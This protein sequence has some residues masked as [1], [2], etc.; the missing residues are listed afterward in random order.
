MDIGN[1]TTVHSQYVSRSS[2]VSTC[3][4]AD[5]NTF[6][7]VIPNACRTFDFTLLFEQSFLSLAPSLLLVLFSCFRLRT[8]LGRDNK[9]LPSKLHSSKLVS[10]L[11]TRSL[12]DVT[13][14]RSSRLFATHAHS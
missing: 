12:C 4:F 13:D 5:D 6:G 2:S 10:L 3:S 1:G 7:P 8:L 14:F 11:T 9:T